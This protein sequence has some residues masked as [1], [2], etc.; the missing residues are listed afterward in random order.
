MSTQ[1]PNI[2]HVIKGWLANTI[3]VLASVTMLSPLAA[4]TAVTPWVLFLIMNLIFVWDAFASKHWSWLA[5]CCFCASWDI[6]LILS[7]STHLDVL[8]V[9]NPLVTILEQLP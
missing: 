4:S 8:G 1:N 6:L 2:I 7:R 9:F 5:L 3:A